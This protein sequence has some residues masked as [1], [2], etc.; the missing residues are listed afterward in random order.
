MDPYWALSMPMG[1][2]NQYSGGI[3]KINSAKAMDGKLRNLQVGAEP[4]ACG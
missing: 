4:Y 2:G 1:F 3:T